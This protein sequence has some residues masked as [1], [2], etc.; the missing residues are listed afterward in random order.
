MTIVTI[1]ELGN[2][3]PHFFQVTEDAAVNGLLLQRPVEALGHTVG[4]RLGNEGETLVDAPEFNLFQEVISG[5]LRA[6]IAKRLPSLT[7]WMPTQQASK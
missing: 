6:M 2:G 5:V 1:P 3:L 4:L 7:A